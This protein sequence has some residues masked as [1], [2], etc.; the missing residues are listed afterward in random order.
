MNVL[1]T[2]SAATSTVFRWKKQEKKEEVCARICR[3]GKNVNRVSNVEVE[4][5][6]RRN[7]EE[8]YVRTNWKMMWNVITTT[9]AKVITVEDTNLLILC[10]KSGH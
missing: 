1:M 5:V 6:L 9:N 7:K 3:K 2:S 8:W 10:R 4:T